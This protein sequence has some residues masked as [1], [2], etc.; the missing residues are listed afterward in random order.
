M[1]RTSACA[2]ARI[3]SRHSSGVTAIGFSQRTWTPACAARTAYSRCMLFG[4]AM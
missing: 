3:M 1:R 2:A 4:S